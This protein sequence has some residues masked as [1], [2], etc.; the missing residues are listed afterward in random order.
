M[1]IVGGRVWS[2]GTSRYARTIVS[3]TMAAYLVVCEAA[4]VILM[5]LGVSA[6]SDQVLGLSAA[7]FEPADTRSPSHHVNYSFHND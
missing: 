1:A 5:R 7:A 4:N 6:L 2:S 3:P